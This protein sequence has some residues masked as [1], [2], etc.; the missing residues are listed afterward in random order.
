MNKD[1][2]FNASDSE[3]P[4]IAYS[5]K[6]KSIQLCLAVKKRTKNNCNREYYR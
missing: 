1:L 3:F 6:R 4:G 2:L 5:V